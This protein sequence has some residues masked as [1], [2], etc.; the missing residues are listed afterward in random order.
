MKRIVKGLILQTAQG[1]QEPY[2]FSKKNMG[3]AAGDSPFC[4]SKCELY[5]NM[6]DM[7]L[8]IYHR[9]KSTGRGNNAFPVK[10]LKLRL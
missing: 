5:S 9:N 4:N 6:L 2:A 8:S 1:I 7:P 3:K 10:S